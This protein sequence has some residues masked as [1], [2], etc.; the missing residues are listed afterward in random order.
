MKKTTEDD[1]AALAMASLLTYLG[2]VVTVGDSHETT[3][4]LSFQLGK[5]RQSETLR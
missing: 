2:K 1:D 4:R 5:V 3:A